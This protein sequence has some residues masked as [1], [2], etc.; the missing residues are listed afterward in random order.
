MFKELGVLGKL[1]KQAAQLKQNMAQVQEQLGKLTV[2][3]QAGGNMVTVRANG[4]QEILGCTI[5]PS[6]LADQDV[7][8]LADLF[9][10]AANQALAKARQA[11]TQA[12]AEGFD[13]EMQEQL[14]KGFEGMM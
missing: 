9:V 13:P 10:V 6:V 2:E 4:K 3:G 14:R 5:D 12:M 1:L 8:M 7:E 11:A